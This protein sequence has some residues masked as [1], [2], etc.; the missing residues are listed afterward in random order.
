MG[1]TSNDVGAI[2]S[3]I[4]GL[5]HE[6]KSNVEIDVSKGA[7]LIAR[8]AAAQDAHQAG[9]LPASELRAIVDDL[10]KSIEAPIE[11]ERSIDN[12]EAAVIQI[13]GL[14]DQLEQTL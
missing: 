10:G 2:L 1:A 13:R 4:H 6:A 5:L 12:P 3:E 8:V 9:S 14:L 7:A 11:K